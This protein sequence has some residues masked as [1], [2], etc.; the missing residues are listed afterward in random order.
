MS[1]LHDELQ[2]ERLPNCHSFARQLEVSAK[3]IQ[4]DIDFMRDRLGLPIEFDVVRN[5]YRYTKPVDQLPLATITEGELVALLVAQKAIAQYQGT[6]FEQP[7]AEA[8]ARLT[9]DLDGPVTIALG[10]ARSAITFKPVGAAPADL[11][12]FRKLSAAVLR[13]MEIEFDYRGLRHSRPERRQLQ[14]WHLCCVDGQWYV[15]G[16]D[17]DRRAKRTFALPRIRKVRLRQ[18]RF[19]RPADFSIR[20]H[21]GTAFGIYTGAGD[22]VIRLRFDGWAARFVRER[23]WHESQKFTDG[24]DDAIELELR[25]SSLEEIERWILG[26]GAHVE[27]LAP[28]ALR[29]RI[30]AAGRALA[31]RHGNR[32]GVQ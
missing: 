24:P 8:F 19:T 13:G 16:H 17:L 27:V 1:R 22:H 5:G 29:S 11:E 10:A 26:F 28:A 12:L 15:I 20:A 18:G 6:P 30:A 4:R 14:P 23:F 7:L 3:T 31:A 25:L 21:L 32:K 2:H 9:R